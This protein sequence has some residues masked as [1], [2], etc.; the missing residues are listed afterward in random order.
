M[1]IKDNVK[2]T[3]DA[4]LLEGQAKA[5]SNTA[6]ILL[7]I[8]DILVFLIFAAI[9]RRS[10]GETSGL[11]AILQIALTAAP[12]AIGWFLVS[13]WVGAYKRNLETQPK[14]MA[15]RTALAW[16]ASWP[17][18]MAL[19]GIF[20]DHGIPPWTFALIALISNMVFLLVWRV[21]FAWINKLRQR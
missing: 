16:V 17:V 1:E 5:P 13:P 7:V 19:R 3:V 12:F 8:G 11:G 14:Q 9:G 15:V 4:T 10:H 20:V 2:K 21:P 18:G 6:R